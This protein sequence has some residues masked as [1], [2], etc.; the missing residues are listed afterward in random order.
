MQDLSNTEVEFNFKGEVILIQGKE[1]ES[2]KSF[3]Q[4]FV[5]KV[6]IDVKQSNLYFMY[7]G[8]LVDILKEKDDSTFQTLSNQEDKRRK[9][10]SILVDET[11]NIEN[12][13]PSIDSEQIICPYQNCGKYIH[14]D[15]DDYKISL[16]GCKNGHEKR[17][18][19]L[20]DFEKTQKIN[21]SD[22]K[23]E[24]CQ[25]KRK[26]IFKMEF[27]YCLN[28]Q[29]NLCPL[30]K[31][32]HKC[33]SIINYD[34]IQNTCLKDRDNTFIGFCK[35]CSIHYC[36]SCIDEHNG[37]EIIP[38]NSIIPK[39]KN[40]KD[41][42]DELKKY[43]DDFNSECDEIINIINNVKKSFNLYYNIKKQRIDNY[44][45]KRS[46]NYYIFSNLNNFQNNE[47]IKKDIECVKNELNIDK[48]MNYIINIYNKINCADKNISDIQMDLSNENEKL[49]KAC[50]TL[51]ALLDEARLS[52]QELLKN[53]CKYELIEKTIFE[54][55]NKKTRISDF[56]LANKCLLI[57][58]IVEGYIKTE[59]V[60][61]SMLVTDKYGFVNEKYIEENDILGKLNH[62][63]SDKPLKM[64]FNVNI[65]APHMHA[66]ALENLAPFCTEGAKILDIGSGS[67]YLTVALS[68]M[69]N[70]TG[71][72]VGIEHIPD[73]YQ[74]GL[75]NVN[76]NY[77]NLLKNKKIIFVNQDGRKGC[78]KYGPYKI[79]HV[80]AASE[81]LPQE[82]IKQLDRN[83]RMFIPIGP[84]DGNQY[85]Y[86][87]DK[88]Q[89][90]NVT[91]KSILSVCYSMLQDVESQ[92]NPE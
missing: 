52:N 79:I 11:N 84:I 19:L 82:L 83:G 86:L 49:T 58:L 12:K 90:G 75:N 61:Y 28:C 38:L 91:Y 22:I 21:I 67:G 54:G 63:Y 29:K 18:V 33:Y 50:H 1:N 87:I 34:E 85:I 64:G 13:N 14:M 31:S 73:L 44:L 76:K 59:N 80:G 35:S 36:M 48:K 66:F 70:D 78:P 20:K 32:N 92:I 27:F 5:Q 30:C 4:K 42:L 3:I 9:R 39:D 89:Y 23:C 56:S 55:I 46:K 47:K 65:S 16:F 81:Q 51:K 8:K 25:K 40:L 15:I 68:K 77:P 62:I 2:M 10:M 53:N 88:D 37:H 72:V 43:I 74:F 71:L 6:G 57:K 17:G 41:S 45:K 60:L 26:E 7:G 24:F 69:I